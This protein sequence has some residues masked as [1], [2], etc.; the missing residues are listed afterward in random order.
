MADLEDTNIF[1][2]LRDKWV[3]PGHK[4]QATVRGTNYFV[5]PVEE[6]MKT[7]SFWDQLE[8]SVNSG[9][10]NSLDKGKPEPR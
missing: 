9:D 8:A 2:R 1:Q 10:Q 4:P 6:W 7:E 3:Q 5:M